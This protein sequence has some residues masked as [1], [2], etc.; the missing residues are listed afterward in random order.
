MTDNAAP[1]AVVATVKDCKFVRKF[2]EVLEDGCV[3]SMMTPSVTGEKPGVFY[4]RY[5]WLDAAFGR[6]PKRI[7]LWAEPLED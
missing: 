5:D 4:L 6:R 2:E 1:V 7:R 3:S